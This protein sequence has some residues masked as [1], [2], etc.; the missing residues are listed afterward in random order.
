MILKANI[1]TKQ[2]VKITGFKQTLSF[3]FDFKILTEG[4][5]GSLILIIITSLQ[6]S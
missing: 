1:Y 2:R 6:G 4:G 3:Y 5:G